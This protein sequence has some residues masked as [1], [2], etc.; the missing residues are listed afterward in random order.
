M[1][2]ELQNVIRQIKIAGFYLRD[3]E[4]IDT[5]V[6]KKALEDAITVANSLIPEVEAFDEA[7]RKA[8]VE[9]NA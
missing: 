7:A 1:L 5:Q 8:L 2:T 6:L 3:V 9:A 4:S